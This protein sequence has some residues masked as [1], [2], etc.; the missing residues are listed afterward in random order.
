MALYALIL[1]LKPAF[2]NILGGRL[3]ISP[4]DI[5]A[6]ILLALSVFIIIEG[7]VVFVRKR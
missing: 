7:A 4:V 1:L 5:T 3:I 6:L 2:V